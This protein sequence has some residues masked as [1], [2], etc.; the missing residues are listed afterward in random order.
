M[1]ICTLAG[2]GEMG[3]QSSEEN[4]PARNCHASPDHSQRAKPAATKALGSLFNAPHM[5][6]AAF[7]SDNPTSLVPARK[8]VV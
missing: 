5:A 1:H 8:V 2:P 7:F 3:R 4:R 6:P